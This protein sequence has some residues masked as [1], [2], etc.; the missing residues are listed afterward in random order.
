MKP[1]T[2]F[3]DC[4][5]ADCSSGKITYSC[6]VDGNE[7]I[8]RYR[9]NI[10]D[11]ET[12]NY[13]VYRLRGHGCTYQDDTVFDRNGLFY[14]VNEN[15]EN[16]LLKITSSIFTLSGEQH[17]F[18]RDFPYY[19]TL[20]L[21]TVADSAKDPEFKSPTVTSNEAVFYTNTAPNVSLKYSKDGHMYE[22]LTSDITMLN[23]NKYYFKAIY[24][25]NENISLKKYGWRLIDVDSGDVLVDTISQNQI[26][27]MAGNIIFSY[28]NFVSDTNYA[29]E[30]FVETQNG[31]NMITEPY[32]FKIVYD[33]MVV[34]TGLKVT[35]LKQEPSVVLDWGEVVIAESK[36]IGEIE[37]I[38]NY[39]I[40]GST[41]V[42]IQNNS[43]I[44]YNYVSTGT[45]DIDKNT[46]IAISTRLI[47]DTDTVILNTEGAENGMF[48][49]RELFY[50]SE[51]KKFVY[52]LI[53]FGDVEY[54]TISDEVTPPHECVWYTIVLYPVV[55]DE[56]E[57][58][59]TVHTAGGGLYPSENTYPG[60][61]TYPSFGDWQDN[62]YKTVII[63]SEDDVQEIEDDSPLEE[64]VPDNDL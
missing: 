10:Y 63:P 58:S 35:P 42:E 29:I 3:S 52:T 50:D 64:Y 1:S 25:Q 61:N 48:I 5:V 51:A 9:L 55:N 19:W 31:Y 28:D 41:S 21:W 8:N 44:E 30:L 20:D 59:V 22:N 12:G 36:V 49:K 34:D 43:K 54:K 45:T 38:D 27:G 62:S 46:Y 18:N 17:I 23:R 24:E 11:V 37:Y 32:H 7:P 53:D 6:I 56:L 14:P 15:G 16:N 60:I 47:E 26:Y 40:E 57:M 33:T 39:P 13:I 2:N 4:C